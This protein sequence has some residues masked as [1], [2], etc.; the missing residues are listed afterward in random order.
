MTDR[1]AAFVAE[2]EGEGED[3]GSEIEGEVVQPAIGMRLTAN[4]RK[5]GGMKAAKASK[6]GKP[7]FNGQHQMLFW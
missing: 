5:C 4:C 7:C 2:L 3:E 1:A 6:C